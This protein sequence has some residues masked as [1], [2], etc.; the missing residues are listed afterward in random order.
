MVIEICSDIIMIT[1]TV[2]A[3]F[4]A[5]CLIFNTIWEATCYLSRR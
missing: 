4:G 3:V 2:L 1:I 5:V